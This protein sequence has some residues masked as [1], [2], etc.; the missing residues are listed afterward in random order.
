[1]QRVPP[2]LHHS[3]SVQEGEEVV[4]WVEDSPTVARLFR[5]EEYLGKLVESTINGHL[6][7]VTFTKVNHERVDIPLG[8]VTYRAYVERMLLGE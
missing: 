3:E 5:G 7:K 8:V 6:V 2:S 1:M 4:R